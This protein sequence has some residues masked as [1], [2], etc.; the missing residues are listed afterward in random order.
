MAG[1]G[2]L[3]SLSSVLRGAVRLVESYS[4]L[5]R[6]RVARPLVQFETTA[7]LPKIL[8]LS[9]RHVKFSELVG[10]SLRS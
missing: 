2:H 4:L 3:R 1:A 10:G 6:T 7:N 8:A 9:E 5:R